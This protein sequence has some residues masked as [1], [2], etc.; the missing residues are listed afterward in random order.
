MKTIQA[1]SR[2]EAGGARG[3]TLD[4]LRPGQCGVVRSVAGAGD[5]RRRLLEMGVVSGTEVRIVRLAPLGDPMEVRLR[6]YHLSIR[7]SEAR[8]VVVEP[9]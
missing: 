1:A 4:T 8:T 7:R 6:G 5:A 3:T 9:A 2:T